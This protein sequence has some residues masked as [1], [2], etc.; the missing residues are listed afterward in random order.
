MNSLD[1]G[2]G[3][4]HTPNK[5]KGEL[6]YVEKSKI[7]IKGFTNVIVM[8]II[9]II[10]AKQSDKIYYSRLGGEHKKG[11][12][13]WVEGTHMIPTGGMESKSRGVFFELGPFLNFFISKENTKSVI[14]EVWIEPEG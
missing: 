8:K 9:A 3:T 10:T 13:W 2:N 5:I 4:S 14:T 12:C 11:R 7:K 1:G 6:N